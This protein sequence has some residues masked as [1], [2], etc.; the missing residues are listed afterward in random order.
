MTFPSV[1]LQ[2]VRLSHTGSVYKWL[3]VSCKFF[4]PRIAASFIIVF[5]VLIFWQKFGRGHS[6][7]N[8]GLNY[9]RGMK[10]SRF[11]ANTSLYLGNGARHKYSYNG[12][13]AQN[14]TCSFEPCA[15]SA[16]ADTRSVSDSWL[17]CCL[18]SLFRC[19]HLSGR[20][21]NSVT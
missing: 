11:S 7:F 13:I 19:L 8:G 9:M 3:N 16:P 18:N 2:S 1:S 21:S 4:H 17:S 6:K 12:W 10:I 14:R 20:R 15:P 5:Y